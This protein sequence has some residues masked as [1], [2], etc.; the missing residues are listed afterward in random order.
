MLLPGACNNNVHLFQ[1]GDYVA[2]LNEMIHDHRLIPWTGVRTWDR[3]S[4]SGWG[5]R[6]ATGTADTL[7]VDTLNLRGAF[8]ALERA[9]CTSSN[10]SP[11]SMPTTLLYEFTVVDDPKTWT[12]A[13]DCSGFPMCEEP[14]TDLRC[15]CITKAITAW[16]TCWPARVLR[17]K[18]ADAFRPG[19]GEG[20]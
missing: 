16:R 3:R 19:A 9:R 15:A 6:G 2:I 17:E 18:S 8:R 1:T 20:W 11:G 4:V 10:G 13:V 14:G 7:V 5:I 12:E